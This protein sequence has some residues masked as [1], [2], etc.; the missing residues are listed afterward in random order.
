MALSYLKNKKSVNTITTGL[1]V[2]EH[3]EYNGNLLISLGK[4]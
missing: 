3:A 4:K 1:D 2:I